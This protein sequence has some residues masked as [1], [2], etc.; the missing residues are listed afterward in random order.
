MGKVAMDLGPVTTSEA[1][2][3]MGVAPATVRSWAHRGH[4]AAITDREGQLVRHPETG[5]CVYWLLDVARAEHATRRRAR[6]T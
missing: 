4:I 2:E 1:A 6:R 5:E 3:S